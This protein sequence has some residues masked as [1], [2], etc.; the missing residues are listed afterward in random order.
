K[1]VAPG[2]T[3]VAVLRDLTIG[4]AFLAAIQAVAPALGVEL[5]PIG[6][7]DAVDVERAVTAFARGSTDGMI[8]PPSTVALARTDRHGGSAAPT[9]R[10]LWIPL[11]GRRRWPDLLWG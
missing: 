10:S 11:H 5:T 1:E 9:T 7:R 8:V 3:R 2:V 4:I 6:I